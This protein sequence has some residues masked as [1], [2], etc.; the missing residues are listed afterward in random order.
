LSPALLVFSDDA[1]FATAERDEYLAPPLVPLPAGVELRERLEPESLSVQTS[2][3]GHPL[4]VKIAYHARW[5]AEGADGPY[6]VSPG[7][8][9]IVPRQHEVRLRYA[10]RTAWDVVGWALSAGGVGW[11]LLGRRAAAPRAV[12]AAARRPEQLDACGLPRPPLRWG[13][14]VPAALVALLA[15]S[16]LAVPSA[17]AT[18]QETTALQEKALQAY[19]EQ[20]FAEAAEYLRHAL[21]RGGGGDRRAELLCLRGESLLNAGQPRDALAPFA[22]LRQEQPAGPLVPRA[23]AG[24]ALAWEAM[25]DLAGAESARRRLLEEFPASEWARA[26]G[27]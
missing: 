7:M 8:M 9:L 18:T 21:A 15:A 13:G 12:R 17:A 27:G 24:E 16:R 5:R 14:L 20:R 22:V 6:L 4:L 11:L 2:R 10:A 23:L 3:P 25:G 19:R 1:R 26:Q